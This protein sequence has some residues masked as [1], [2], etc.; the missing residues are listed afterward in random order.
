MRIQQPPTYPSN[1]LAFL[2]PLT[3]AKDP[4]PAKVPLNIIDVAPA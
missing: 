4:Q 2:N 3:T 1:C